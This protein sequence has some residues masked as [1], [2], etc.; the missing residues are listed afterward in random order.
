M[1]LVPNFSEAE[2]KSLEA[3]CKSLSS[4]LS[5]ANTRGEGIGNPLSAEIG[6]ILKERE[7]VLL[8][9]PVFYQA[10]FIAADRGMDYTLTFMEDIRSTCNTEKPND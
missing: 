10:L 2:L 1:Q 5:A 6:D 3:A 8:G 9:S 7:G 4:T